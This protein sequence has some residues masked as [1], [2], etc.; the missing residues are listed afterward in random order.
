MFGCPVPL[1]YQWFLNMYQTTFN[2]SSFVAL[3]IFNHPRN[4]VP[5]ARLN[6]QT[7]RIAICAEILIHLA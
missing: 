2:A 3:A 4:S 1:F 5:Q 7:Y 6:K